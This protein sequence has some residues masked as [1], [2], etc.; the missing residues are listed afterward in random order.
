MLNSLDRELEQGNS[1]VIPVGRKKDGSLSATSKVF[2][3]EEFEI[4]SRYATKKIKSLGGE[5]LDGNIRLQPYERDKKSACDYC[6]FQAVCGFDKGIPGCKPRVLSAME[7][8]EILN[9]MKEQ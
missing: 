1:T 9:K 8:E 3:R 6:P 5:I 4:L 2:T 7:E